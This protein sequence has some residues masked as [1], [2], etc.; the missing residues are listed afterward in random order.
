MD[1]IDRRIDFAIQNYPLVPLPQGFNRRLMK[2]V[3]LGQPVFRLTYLDLLL[4]G[5]LGLFGMGTVAAILLTVPMLD[6]LWLPRLKL[7][8]QVFLGRL[9][10]LP[11]WQ[12]YVLPLMVILGMGLLVG[13]VLAALLP[14]RSWERSG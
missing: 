14:V 6:P 13:V 8:Y 10:L 7:A 1:E 4:P 2:R 11:D 12:P 3:R 5:F 9:A